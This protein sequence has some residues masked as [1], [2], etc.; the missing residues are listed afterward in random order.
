ML[1]DL[2]RQVSDVDKSTS[3]VTYKKQQAFDSDDDLDIENMGF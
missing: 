1:I 2:L 3:T